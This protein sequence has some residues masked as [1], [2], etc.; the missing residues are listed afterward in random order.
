MDWRL[1]QSINLPIKQLDVERIKGGEDGIYDT[2]HIYITIYSTNLRAQSRR[3]SAT[4][5]RN[6]NHWDTKF[7]DRHGEKLAGPH[8][9]SLR[10]AESTEAAANDFPETY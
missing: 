8:R 3:V 10:G 4:W 7:D 2:T 5:C 6:L 1:G 9:Y